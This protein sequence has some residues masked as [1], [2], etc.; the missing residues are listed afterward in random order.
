MSSQTNNLPAY[1][2]PIVD[3]KSRNTTKDWYFFFAGLFQG[4][5]PEK[6]V[7]V[8]LTGSPFVY[9]APKKG[10]VIVSGGTVSAIDFSR[11]GTTFYSTGATA[12]MFTVNKSDL[13]RI[14][15]TVAPTVTFV[16]T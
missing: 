8:T 1:P 10:S 14:T 12:G 3:P 16:P 6:E 4:L 5:P 15:Y 2:T 11:D 13:L 9:S 7:G